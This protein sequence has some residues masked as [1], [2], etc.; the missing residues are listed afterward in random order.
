MLDRLIVEPLGSDLIGSLADLLIERYLSGGRSLEKVVCVFGGRRPALFLKSRLSQKIKSP[1]FP[2][3]CFSIDDFVN[4]LLGGRIPACRIAE[5]EACFVLYKLAAETSPE[6][7]KGRSTFAAFFPWAREILAFIEQLDLEMIS[8]EALKRIESSAQIGYDVPQ[9][10]N[11]LLG[12]VIVLREVFHRRL[13]E[14]GRLTRGLAY[15]KAAQLAASGKPA[16]MDEV[17]FC[18]FFY[19]HRAEQE[20]IGSFYKRQEG[21]LIFEGDQSE[22]SVLARTAGAL[23]APIIPQ[24]KKKPSF[25]LSLYSGFDLHS[26]ASMVREILKKIPRPEETVIL[27][28]EPDHAIPLLSEI[29]SV[30][31]DFNISLGYPLKRSSLSSLLS[32]VFCVQKTRREGRYY[33]KDYLQVLRHPLVKNLALAGPA[34]QTRI[35]VHKI[36]EILTG[37]IETPLAGTLFLDLSEIEKCEDVYRLSV[38]TALHMEEKTSPEEL[39]QILAQIHDV[40]LRKWEDVSDFQGLA[41]SLEVLL[42]L[43]SEKSVL[44]RY[45]LDEAIVGQVTGILREWKGSRFCSEV[46]EKEDIFKIFS[47][48]LDRLMANFS[49]SPLKGLQILGL[50]ETRSLSFK[51]VIVMDANE[52]FLPRVKVD[53]PLIPREVMVSLGLNRLEKEEEIQKYQ[54]SRLIRGAED[55]HLV[56]EDSPEKEKSRFIEEII[57]KK[58]KEA[59]KL[60]VFQIPRATF[61]VKASVRR[62]MVAK[63]KAHVDFL[64]HFSFSP[65]S[66]NTYLHCPLRFF[67]QYVLG[68]KEK[69]DLWDEP[70]ARDVGIFIHALLEESFAEF[71]GRR[72]VLDGKF[73]NRFFDLF[74]SLFER[75]FSRKMRSDAFL[76]KEVMRVRLEGFFEAEKLRPV[77]SIYCL[78]QTFLQEISFASQKAVFKGK[79]DRVDILEDE[80]LL[81]LDYKTGGSDLIPARGF[82]LEGGYPARL[83]MKKKIRSFQ[84]PIYLLLCRSPFG[85]EAMNAGL[86]HIRACDKNGRLKTLFKEETGSEEREEVLERLLSALGGLVEEI[87]DSSLPFEADEDDAFYCKSCPYFCLCR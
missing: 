17:F 9:S 23:G 27:L 14:E 65:S 8:S 76:L 46:F 10:I 25:N 84:L 62:K 87:R 53:E 1:F 54:F 29:S 48:H 38:Q 73:K 47:D 37:I 45:P 60:D 44:G 69:E 61:G 72:P 36:E 13:A 26:Q 31:D 63:E 71:V 70:E 55:V 83:E 78:E 50:F 4:D 22:W 85:R 49:G 41:D 6:I 58:Q 43:L 11:D 42:S 7:L 5:L 79:I 3:R 51:H 30:V 75:D 81:V 77:R 24:D 21:T 86:Y 59:G 18:H 33:A 57:W 2:P 28:P 80:S 16:G 82:S 74:E 20:I 40:F 32:V 19:L 67:Y 15:L 66:V 35:L 34:A 39:R 12:H 56:F 68:L 64:N 52:S